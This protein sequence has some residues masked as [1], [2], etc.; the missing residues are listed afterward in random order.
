[1]PHRLSQLQRCHIMFR[2]CEIGE[3]DGNDAKFSRIAFAGTR[4]DVLS[5]Q[6]AICADVDLRGARLREIRNVDSLHGTTMS[7]EQIAD[8]SEVFARSIGIRT[9]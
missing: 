2:D 3:L 5:L 6:H 7:L 9:Q 8:L 1:M 4:I